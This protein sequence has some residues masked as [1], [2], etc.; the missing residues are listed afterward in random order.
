MEI[1]L[2]L[3]FDL[4]EYTSKFLEHSIESHNLQLARVAPEMSHA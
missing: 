4:L 1:S 3:K 2:Q